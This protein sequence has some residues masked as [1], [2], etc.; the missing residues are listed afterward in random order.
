M[1]IAYLINNGIDLHSENS[2]FIR[3]KYIINGLRRAGH[4]VTVLA[5]DGRKVIV[6]EDGEMSKLARLGIT[7]SAG[8]NIL[9][10]IVR[11]LQGILHL[12]YLGFFDSIRFYEA[13]KHELADYDVFVEHGGLLSWGGILASRMLRKPLLLDLEADPF[14]EM[15]I[16]KTPLGRAQKSLAD[17]MLRRSLDNAR[18]IAAVSQV[19]KKELM[20]NWGILEEKIAV[21]PNGVD[22]ELFSPQNIA[23]DLK[24]QLGLTNEVVVTFIGSFFPWHG[25]DLLVEAFSFSMKEEQNSKLLLVGD[26]LLMNKILEIIRSQ[27]LQDRVILTGQVDHQEIPRYLSISDICV[28]P[29][30]RLSGDLWF[31]PMKIY[32][33]MAAGKALVASG[34]GQIAEIIES[35]VNGILVEPGNKQQL[36]K[37]ILDLAKDAQLRQ[38]LGE[39]A[40]S[41][42]VQ[43]HSW[44]HYTIAIEKVLQQTVTQSLT[45]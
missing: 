25:V 30:P 21:I 39:N 2:P 38:L 18:R 32:E 3:V 20:V 22:T 43:H 5:L 31:S 12:P 24:S 42:A 16:L 6:D 14:K 19:E 33:Y 26:G 28:A 7:G 4:C 8:W 45:N 1:R 36:A 10:S 44:R 15:E 37:A 9:E 29:Y 23:T 34:F 27:G 35:G 13:C 11:R 40:R 17:Y 41:R